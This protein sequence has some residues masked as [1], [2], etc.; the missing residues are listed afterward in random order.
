VNH[1]LL[2][3]T[4]VCVLSASVLTA[5]P[6]ASDLPARAP[7]PAIAVAGAPTTLGPLN[8]IEQTPE[9]K[10][11]RSELDRATASGDNAGI[12]AVHDRIQALYLANQP[13]N[14][15]AAKS[16][17]V[18]APCGVTDYGSDAL[19][20]GRVVFSTAADYTMD[21]TMYAA[22]ATLDSTAMVYRSTDHGVT[23]SSLCGVQSSPR[24]IYGKVGLVVS[25]GDSARIFLFFLHP[26]NGGDVY[27]VRF[28]LDGTG[29]LPRNVLVGAADTIGDFAFCR[30]N[31]NHYYLYG[32]AYPITSASMLGEALRSTDYGLTWAVTNPLGYLNQVSYQNG[33]GRWQYMASATKFPGH[34]G[35][36]NTI[37]NHNYGD[38]GSWYQTDVWPDGNAVEEPVFAPA[39]TTPETSAVAWLAYHHTNPSGNPFSIMTAYTL[40]GG[41]TFST[42]AALASETGA[43]DVWPDLKPYR[44]T[45]NDYMNI[46]YIS[47]YND[48][49]RVFRRYAQAP[50][51][52]V[53][54]DTSRVNNREAYRDHNLKPLLLYSTGSPGTGGGCVFVSY[55]SPDSMFWN[56]PWM[57]AV[58][59]NPAQP[60][61]PA[62]AF[63]VLPSV[64]RGPV[65]VSWNGSAMRL[66]V[67]DVAGRTVRSIAAPA[68]NS[69]VWD[70]KVPAGTYLVCLTTSLG[71]ATRP[72]VIQ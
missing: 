62:A 15:G 38:P 51:P 61:R 20:S 21:G 6:R 28:N 65:R 2:T 19:I 35:M 14:S 40:D 33:A 25:E 8:P 9:M 36:I 30:D 66:T 48:F 11:L 60:G 17:P 45:G 37:S 42:P 16:E 26:D 67:T 68:G 24:V 56:A 49:R 22:A 43:G 3:L 53:W 13:P 71:T 31:D 29:F 32:V 69:F 27:V 18:P 44:S 34:T 12:K 4:L 58:A 7:E 46:S 57:T 47:L 63:S 1:K 52:G 23:W 39:F 55:A 64:A 70:G 54:S 59:E 50:E 72:V 5:A 10:A 41:V